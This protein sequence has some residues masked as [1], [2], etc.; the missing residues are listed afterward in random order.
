M[1]EA[2]LKEPRFAVEGNYCVAVLPHEKLARPEELI[3]EYL[4]SNDEIT[5]R[6]ARELTGIQ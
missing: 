4:E 6:I 3:M 2:R 1:T 5:N